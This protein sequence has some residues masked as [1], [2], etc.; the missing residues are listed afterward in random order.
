MKEQIP[1]LCIGRFFR[2]VLENIL[3]P[4]VIILINTVFTN[5]CWCWCGLQAQYGNT[6]TKFELPFASC[7]EKKQNSFQ[8][9]TR[10]MKTLQ[11]FNEKEIVKFSK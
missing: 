2:F 11:V 8:I 4:S 7:S 3:W 10:G 1:S 5:Q 6:D 9:G